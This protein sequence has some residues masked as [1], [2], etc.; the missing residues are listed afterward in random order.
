MVWLGGDL[1]GALEP[2][3]LL[4]P[5]SFVGRSGPGCVDGD[6]PLGW[7]GSGSFGVLPPRVLQARVWGAAVLG[8]LGH[9]LAPP[10]GRRRSVLLCATGSQAARAE[11]AIDGQP[12]GLG[13]G[14]REVSSV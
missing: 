13:L 4:A 12:P 3:F 5:S 1:A 8:R 9:G 14:V 6:L 7:A 2:A 10:R 11:L